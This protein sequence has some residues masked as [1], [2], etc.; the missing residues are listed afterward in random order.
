MKLFIILLSFIKVFTIQFNYRSLALNKNRFFKQK[1]IN[2]TKEE[3]FSPQLNLSDVKYNTV[4]SNQ[5]QA[6][7]F[8]QTKMLYT[9]QDDDV[10]TY[11]SIFK[12]GKAEFLF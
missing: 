5:D 11:V 9:V 3:D 1:V 7:N 8:P 12:L 6:L 4:I 10:K 2:A